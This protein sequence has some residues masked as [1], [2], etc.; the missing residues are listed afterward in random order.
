M[1]TRPDNTKYRNYILDFKGVAVM[2][3]ALIFSSLLLGI[4]VVITEKYFHIDFRYSN[5][6][7]LISY[8]MSF[9]PVIWAFDYFIVR[10]NGK[11]LNFNMQTKNVGTYL[12]I[13]P[14]MFGMMLISEF[15]TTLIP[16]KGF[17]FGKWYEIFSQQINSIAMDTITMFLLTSLFAP[18]LEEILF[19]GII[20]KGLINKGVKPIHAIFITAFVFGFIHMN[21]WQFVGG[22]LLGLVLGLVYFKTKSLLM[23]ILLHAFNNFIG[24]LLITKYKTESFADSFNIAEWQVLLAGIVIFSVF[25][26]LFMFRNKIV[27]KE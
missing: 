19:R 26:Y 8:I 13:F 27:H 25:Y 2:F 14:M 9:L 24:S 23:P 6:F 11:K 22:F 7:T 17:I 10:R 1:E 20:Q 15:I 12:T 18:I 16:I 21:P 5:Y 3:G 4:L